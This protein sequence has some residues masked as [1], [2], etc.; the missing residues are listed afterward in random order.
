MKKFHVF[1]VETS[2]KG[3]I[4]AQVG[5]KEM[6]IKLFTTLQLEEDHNLVVG[7]EAEFPSRIAQLIEASLGI[8][9]S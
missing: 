1:R 2:E 3:N 7:E 4:W 5:R 8:K 6:G 9:W